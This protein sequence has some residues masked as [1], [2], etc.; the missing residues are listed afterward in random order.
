MDTVSVRVIDCRPV[1]NIAFTTAEPID[2]ICSRECVTYMTLTDT[3]AGGPQTYTWTFHGGSPGTSTL[4]NPIVCYNLPG[5]FNVILK[6][7]NPYPIA[8]G[9]SERTVGELSYIKVVDVPNITIIPPGN[10]H[11]DTTIRFGQTIDLKG[12][13][14]KT[15]QWSPNYNI[16]SLTDPKVTIRPFRNT[17]YILTGYNSKQCGSSDTLNVFVIEDCGEMFVPNAFSPNGDGHNDVLQVKG[18]CLETL[19]FMIFNRWGEKVF[20]TI[21]QSVGWDG[22]FKGE[23]MNTGVYV[24]RLEGKTYD[25]KGFSAK[26]NITL[27]R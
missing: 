5:K 20:E 11:S 26:G 8:D 10:F 22:T 14:G 15:Y 16:T 25:G 23:E 7:K 4:A 18:I 19:S 2:T 24:Y 3:M 12:T 9:G 13:G 6:V 17:Q 1:R 27:I 21:D